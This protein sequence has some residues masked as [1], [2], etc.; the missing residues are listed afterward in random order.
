MTGLLSPSFVHGKVE[1]K[2][3]LVPVV[4]TEPAILP[5][6][7][8]SQSI[9]GEPPSL[10]PPPLIDYI[11]PTQQQQSPTQYHHPQYNSYSSQ[12]PDY[13]KPDHHQQQQQQQYEGLYTLHHGQHGAGTAAAQIS[14][15]VANT[16]DQNQAFI[17]DYHNLMSTTNDGFNLQLQQLMG[18]H[19]NAPDA[20]APLYNQHH[21]AD[22]STQPPT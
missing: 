8:S 22:M 15:Q 9:S 2:Q 7:Q 5:P 4:N 11:S 3:H 19:W 10:P 14:P 20:M 6:L 21:L 18:V 1:P 16:Y 13:G 17:P 12:V